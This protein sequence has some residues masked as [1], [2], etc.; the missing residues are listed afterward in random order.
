MLQIFC[1]DRQRCLVWH[2][3]LEPSGTES[4]HQFMHL[5]IDIDSS[6][7]APLSLQRA[8]FNDA[9]E[10]VAQTLRC[11]VTHSLHSNRCLQQTSSHTQSQPVDVL[12]RHAA[13]VHGW[14]QSSGQEGNRV[15]CYRSD[16]NLG[17]RLHQRLLHS[18][19]FPW[20]LSPPCSPPPSVDVHLVEDCS[21]RANNHF[22]IAHARGA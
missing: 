12:E 7:S 5:I 21:R 13:C 15:F 3:A 8:C 1:L 10:S 6:R 9:R 16:C 17:Q 2:T 20:I 4:G 22:R 18:E 14:L 11:F 19:L